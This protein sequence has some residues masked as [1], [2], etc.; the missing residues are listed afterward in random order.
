[1]T[2]PLAPKRE[3]SLPHG[4]GPTCLSTSHLLLLFSITA[5]A[6]TKARVSGPTLATHASP[7]EEWCVRGCVLCVCVCVCLCA[8]FFSFPCVCVCVFFLCRVLWL[9]GHR[10]SLV[11]FFF[12][13]YRSSF[14]SRRFSVVGFHTLL[15]VFIVYCVDCPS[16]SVGRGW[17][18]VVCHLPFAVC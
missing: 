8:C 13:I 2:W 5:R 14:V 3:Y 12:I 18:L 9:L 1:M 11:A 7:A 16:P 15:V 6:T 10:S 17:W 4:I